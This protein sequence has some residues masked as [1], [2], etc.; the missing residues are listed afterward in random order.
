MPVP[1]QIIPEGSLQRPKQVTYIND[2]TEII[3]D[4]V[5]GGG[6]ITAAMCVFSS[7]KGRDGQIITI[8]NGLEEFMNEYGLGDFETYGQPLLNAY[9]IAKAASTSGAMVHCFE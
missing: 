3:D 6:T 7:P 4:Y 2:N 5:A 9:N 1:Y 8:R